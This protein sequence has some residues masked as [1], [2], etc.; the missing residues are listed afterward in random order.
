MKV[1]LED[2]GPCRKIVHISAPTDVVTPEY[3]RIAALFAERGRV[4]GFRPGKVP[5]KVAERY[6]AKAIAEETKERLIPRLY[7]EALQQVGLRP[8]A[9]ISV[10]DVELRGGDGMSFKVTVDVPPD[11]KLPRYKKIVLKDVR[12]EVTAEECQ[13]AIERLRDSRARYED[14]T[15][16]PVQSGDLVLVDYSGVAEGV[17][18]AQKVSGDASGLAEGKDF[19]VLVDGQFEFL[20]GFAN[21]LVGAA[22]GEERAVKV[23]FPRDHR[24]AGLAGL[25]AIYTVRIKRIRERRRPAL[26]ADFFKQFEVDSEEALRDK[27]RAL[28]SE[29]AARRRKEALRDQLTARLLEETEMDIPQSVVEEETNDAVRQIVRRIVSQGATLENVLQ[30]R[31]TIRNTATKLSTDRVKLAYILDRIATEEK[32]EVQESEVEERLAALAQQYGVTVD[33]LRAELDKR[34]GWESLH[35]D[36]LAEK[37]LNFLLEH[38]KIK[39]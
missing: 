28:L 19:W 24:M 34:N 38:A 18:L 27:V 14:V 8:V 6:Y 36:V 17:P 33:Q 20:P 32:I 23:V 5:L 9:V 10:K 3:K 26:D 2:A 25:E 1:V 35:S 4:P 13:Q 12:F 30:Q 7:R 39:D 11:F 31:E 37:T 16:R 21:G 15:G 22:V 29:A